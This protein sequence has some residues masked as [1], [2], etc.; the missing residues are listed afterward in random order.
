MGGY[1]E[2]LGRLGIDAQTFYDGL[3]GLYDEAM[4][5]QD[6]QLGRLVER[7][8]ARGEWQRTLLIIAADHGHPA[9]SFP[10]FGRGLWSTLYGFIALD[11]D[12]VTIEGITFYEHKETPGLGG[13][14]D[15][16]KWKD[17]W[18]G[19]RA[20]GE[21]N[22]PRIA[23]IR[24]RAGPPSEDPYRVDGL[25]G[26]TMTSRGVG[27]LVRFWLGDDGFGAYLKTLRKSE[28]KS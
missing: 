27:R 9:G 2:E 20:F 21:D 1:R 14:V 13:E 28:V 5:H 16:P 8:K 7:L 4:E 15:N 24:G 22:E 18:T 12:L 6:Y 25:A 26:A 3:R 23:V 10:R 19:R 11:A 17:L